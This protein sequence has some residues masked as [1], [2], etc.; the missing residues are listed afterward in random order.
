MMSDWV[1]DAKNYEKNLVKK[2]VKENRIEMAKNL[3]DVLDVEIIAKKFNLTVREVKALK[4]KKE[5]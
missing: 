5:N 2:A 1:A 3:L 4:R